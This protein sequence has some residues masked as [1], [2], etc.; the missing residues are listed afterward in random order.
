MY[1]VV[2]LR[3]AQLQHTFIELTKKLCSKLPKEFQKMIIIVV[4]YDANPIGFFP[5]ELANFL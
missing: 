4:E 1:Q 5:N 2:G 3:T